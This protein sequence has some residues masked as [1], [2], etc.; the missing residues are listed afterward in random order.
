[1][2]SSKSHQPLSSSTD[3]TISGAQ[4]LLL[5]AL[6]LLAAQMVLLGHAFDFFDWNSSLHDPTHVQ[7]QRLGVTVFFLLSGF[8]IPWSVARPS[9]RDRHRTPT[10]PNSRF[11]D[12]FIDR[13]TRIYSGLVPAL[14]F[15][16]IADA[17]PAE[18]FERDYPP[19]PGAGS[20]FT[21]LAN[22]LHLQEF[23]GTGLPIFGTGDPLWSLSVEW[24]LYVLFGLL[25]LRPKGLWL[26]LW[27]PA[28]ISV[29]WNSV[30]GTGDGIALV[31]F[32]GWALFL[33]WRRVRR[34]TLSIGP[35]WCLATFGAVA[36]LMGTWSAVEWGERSHFGLDVPFA[37]A[38]AVAL[39]A[40]L[41][42]LGGSSEARSGSPARRD[43]RG[44]A[45]W[46]HRG[47]AYSFT[48]YLTHFTVL[49]LLYEWQGEID[50]WILVALACLLC[51]AV[52]WGLSW[53]GER[54]TGRLR[55]WARDHI[56]RSD[57]G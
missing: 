18:R 46:V 37:L 55:G 52:A 53:A 8:L 54:H 38:A 49:T 42:A 23:P 11:P 32:L 39:L 27:P 12:Y 43:V 50:A 5:D 41:L 57:T 13:G 2:S 29:A 7:I 24:W 28:V 30:A 16:A 10:A 17:L 40:W 14:V 20:A 36:A 22:L 21:W 3:L 34:R 31:W 1:M 4:S 26:L 15:I 45:G 47:A 6:R 25:V 33:L 19:V 56:A 48:L 9:R 44:V 51:N 35:R